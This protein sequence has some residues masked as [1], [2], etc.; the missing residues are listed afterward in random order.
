MVTLKLS[1]KQLDDLYKEMF[2]TANP[3]IR[4]KC[5]IVYLRAKGRP[6]HEIADIARVDKDTVTN[7][8]KK[9]VGGGLAGLLKENY[10]RPKSQLE[11]CNEQL[12]TLFQKQPP[13]TVNHA[14]EM[15]FEETG[16]RLKLSACQT[17]LKKMGM[18]CRR[19]GLVPGKAMEDEK[20]PQ[21]QQVFHDQKLQPLLD[22]AKQGKRSVLFVN[23]AHFVMGAF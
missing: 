4:K 14:I 6:C 2:L 16:V 18:K 1:E 23:A 10:R 22:E 7:A 5:L 19:Y 13:H 3:R 9:Y 11:P 12:R 20:Q 8:I 17:F 21:A 15:I